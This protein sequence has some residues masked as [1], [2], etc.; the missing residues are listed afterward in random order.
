MPASYDTLIYLGSRPS[1]HLNLLHCYHTQ[2]QQ[3]LSFLKR[4]NSTTAQHSSS[5]S[6]LT[7]NAF[8]DDHYYPHAKASKRLAYHDWSV[9]NTHI[10]EQLGQYKLDELTNPVLDVWVRQQ[11]LREYKRSTINKHI[12]LMNRML[13]L[14]RHWGHIT[15]YSKHQ[16]NIKKLATGDYTQRFL[17]EP[18]I[19]RLLKACRSSS[20]PFLYPFV[21]LLLL[22][23][24]RNG[25]ARLMRWRD[26]DAVNRIWT[27]PRSKNGRSR[28]I[29]LSSAALAVLDSTRDQ[30]TRLNLPTKPDC[31]VFTNPQ[32]RS[33]YYSFYASWFSARDQADLN[34][35]RIHDLRHTYAS[36]L[37]NKGVSLYEV[38]T[39][40]GHSSIQMTQRYAHLE[41]N[42]LHQRTEIVSDA[43]SKLSI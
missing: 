10:R 21:Q 7:L 40:L 1:T 27:V 16:Q 24:A 26:V 31:Y 18:E 4:S 34:D 23:G 17:S 39:L 32:T 2:E 38:Q 41:P 3:M 36:M 33:A 13:N 30:A 42:L 22:T 6:Q 5:V 35:V 29:V 9:Y 14:A 25:E 11:V 12:H 20:N 37:I 19:N 15:G 8:F 43:I 28:R